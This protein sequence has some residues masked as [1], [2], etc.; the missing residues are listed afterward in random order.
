MQGRHGDRDRA[1]LSGARGRRLRP[2][3][4]RRPRPGRAHGD[5]RL[6]GR[7]GGRAASRDDVTES[8]TVMRVLERNAEITTR[9][10]G[11]FV[12]SIDGLEGDYGGGRLA[13]LV[14]LRQRGRVD[15]RRRRRPAPG[16]RGDLVGLPR[17]VGGDLG[18]GRR[19]L[20][21]AALRRRLRGARAPD[22]RRMPR[23]RRR[24]RDGGIEAAGTRGATLTPRASD[25]EPDPGPGRP[26]GR[27]SRR[28][29]AASQLESG[30]RGQR[31][32]R[33][34]RGER[35]RRG[36]GRPRSG[37]RGGAGAS[38]PAAGLVAATRRGGGPPTWVVTG[39]GASGVDG[40][41]RPARRRP[42]CG[43]TYAVATEGGAETPLPL[44]S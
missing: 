26:L 16:R 43:T 40:G 12:Q 42:R 15:R 34:I 22:R 3:P 32:L 14:L 27:G 18:P 35:R 21:A 6:R 13:R 25:A 8:D 9:Y 39:A 5:P 4:R 10:G 20:L 33:P 24:L 28:D 19:R 23:R 37:G 29:P 7:A 38:A 11:G 41:R 2:R 36:P 30:P 44:G 1:A 31:R 17:L